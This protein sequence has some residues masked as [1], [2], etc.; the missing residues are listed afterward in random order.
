MPA[1]TPCITCEL[2]S[3]EKEKR[4]KRKRTKVFWV[5]HAS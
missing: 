2:D 3:K 5:K 4:K 1:F